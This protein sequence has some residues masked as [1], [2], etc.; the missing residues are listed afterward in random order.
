MWP[1]RQEAATKLARA[2]KKHSETKRGLPGIA[3]TEVRQT[4][5]MQMVASIR[6]LD[7][8]RILR[9]RDVHPDRASPRSHMFDPERAAI[10]YARKGNIDEAVWITF[11]ATHFGRHAKH[12]WRRMTDVYSG[13][14]SEP[15]TWDR[16][17]ATP[18]EFCAWL[19]A[20]A[21]KIGGGFGNHRKWEAMSA[22]WTQA[23]A[24]T[25]LSYV[26]WIGPSHSVRF[27]EFVREAGNDPHVI[28]DHVYRIMD[29]QRF[30]RLAKFDFLALLG[31]L[32]LLPI[33]PGSA[34]LVGATGPTRGARLL[35]GGD[36]TAKISAP[37]LEAWLKDLD[38]DVKVGMQVLEDSLCNWQKS[39]KAFLHFRG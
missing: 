20:N 6:R 35:Y 23:T 1:K 14:G 29:V 36:P 8:T 9:G 11:M 32:Q 17:S 16:V 31:R 22:D 15:W 13:L 4:L 12:G 2:L 3:S 10:F 27:S 33:E 38:V 39:P 18:D 7:F 37:T 26:R 5:A 34:Y 21:S 24:S 30:G 25:I 28:F 19:R